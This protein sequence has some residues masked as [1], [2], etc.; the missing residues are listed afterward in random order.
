MRTLMQAFGRRWGSVALLLAIWFQVDGYAQLRETKL[1]ASDLVDQEFFGQAVAI[2]G[3][4]I[5][6]GAS[7]ADD[8]GPQSGSAYIFERDGDSW[9]ELT[10]L[11]ASD[12]DSAHYFGRSVAIS[13]PYAIV[14]APYNN[15]AGFKS[16]AAYIFENVNG[17]WKETAILVP[18]DADSHDEFGWSVAIDGSVAV[19]GVRYDEDFGPNSGS[20]YV[21]ERRNGTWVEVAK[22]TAGDA[23]AHDQFGTSVAVSKEIVAVGSPG[24]DEAGAQSGSVY[25]F[26]RLNG[27]W[28][29]TAKI[30]ASDGAAADFFGMSV[31][32]SSGII[33][34][35]SPWDDDG[36]S[37]S[38]SAYVFRLEGDSWIEKAKL[39][40]S[41]A[42]SEDGFGYSVSLNDR[43]LIVGAFGTSG[44]T[45]AAYIFSRSPEAFNVWDEV[46]KVTASDGGANDS[47]GLAVSISGQDAVVG[48]LGHDSAGNNSGSAYVYDLRNLPLTFRPTDDTFVW[49]RKP[50]KNY[51]ASDEM[52]VRRTGSAKTVTYL[53]FNVTGLPGTVTSAKVQLLAVDFSIDMGKIYRAS[54]SYGNSPDLWD[55]S[56]L[57][58]TNAPEILG[59]PLSPA[60]NL[61][62]GR[63][64]EFDVTPAITGDG[65]YSFAIK[66]RSNDVAKYSSKE[67]VLAPRL[68]IVTEPETI[69]S[70]VIDAFQ[71]RF[72][73][74][75]SRVQIHGSGL[76]GAS[77]VRFGGTP[78]TDFT[79]RSDALI[80]ATVPNG[81][82]QSGLISV[83][84]PGGGA[85]SS[86]FFVVETV[87]VVK[88]FAP[89]SGTVGSQVTIQT[90]F[91][92][93]VL[94]VAFNGVAAQTFSPGLDTVVVATVPPGA[95]TG[96]ISI[97]NLA[98]TGVSSQDFTVEE[99]SIQRLVFLPTDDAFVR[100]S[101]P[102]KNYGSS[103]ELRVRKSRAWQIA[104]LK[105]EVSG[106]SGNVLSAKVRLL[107][108]DG[109]EDMGFIYSVSNTYENTST[110]WTEEGLLW[111]NA[112][113]V[114]GPGLGT[115]PAS[116]AG[117][118][119][120]YD[121]LPA[122]AGDGT[123]SFAVR[124]NSNDVVKFSS[125]EGQMAPQLVIEI[126][127]PPVLASK[128]D[129][130]DSAANHDL[131]F[132]EPLPET[133]VL[134]PNYPNPFN[135]E[136]HI[137]Y[138]LPEAAHVRLAIFNV[139]GQRV[140]LLVDEHQSA[141]FQIVTWNGRN[142][143]GQSVGSGMY[144]MRL[145]VGQQVRT[146]KMILQK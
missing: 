127:S 61:G 114:S 134:S 135:P 58:W 120:E 54:N 126:G 52:R 33:S 10:E 53:K 105:F 130:I 82:P 80:E 76:T 47:F 60:N 70:P 15:P 84:T 24:D 79:V 6:I 131:E 56:G 55:E 102:Q 20:A 19:I 139:R 8:V 111:T 42:S 64:F 118:T 88:S 75:G 136:T 34:V 119:V 63:V 13:R 113:E 57:N 48:A 59:D 101:R 4:Y 95:T 29:E 91:I 71:P 85:V 92:G 23:A 73:L 17:I 35:G 132:G 38:G 16:G 77:E 36:G 27:A 100:S 103:F 68:V 18:Q 78:A 129:E 110:P 128:S 109:G 104:Y 96:K 137:R 39:T 9:S 140:R 144:F 21:F 32:V 11:H 5:L 108:L 89:T 37:K 26:E 125:K 123:Y 74:V 72:V 106:L 2:S 116:A 121:V 65:Q 14:G 107:V 122:I 44:R 49:S 90:S 145:E 40:A 83:T 87:P 28:R 133:L 43:L 112:P 45:G 62:P 143:F 22:L 41:D 3:D 31:A 67:G 12:G 46:A 138:G 69:P 98:G 94:G 115:L 7:G 25:V 141:G 124:I 117:D 30:W 81:A 86:D 142:D 51:G 50:T 97:T 66:N 146:G 99:P 1:M 93:Q